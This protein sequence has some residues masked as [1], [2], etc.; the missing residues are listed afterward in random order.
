MRYKNVDK[1]ERV[2][3]DEKVERKKRR[4]K[5]RG[6]EERIRGKGMRM[7]QKEVLLLRERIGFK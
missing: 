3:Y 6:G 1:G 7:E 2:E 4:E 5:E